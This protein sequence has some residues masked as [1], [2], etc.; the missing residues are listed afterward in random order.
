MGWNLQV[1]KKATLAVLVAFAKLPPL[2]WKLRRI[3]IIIIE[4]PRP[5]LPHIMGFLLPLLSR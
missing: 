5:R 4:I 1:K 2:P 3:E